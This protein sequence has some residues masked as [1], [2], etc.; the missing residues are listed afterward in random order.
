MDVY[1]LRENIKKSLAT[2]LDALKT[3]S[4][5]VFHKTGEYLE[6]KIA[7]TVIKSNDHKN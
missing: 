5:K 6:N 4:K 7:D 1:H 2:G 3:A